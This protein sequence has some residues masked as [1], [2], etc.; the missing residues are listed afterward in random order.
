MTRTI[1][2][3]NARIKSGKV[4]VVTAE[5]LIDRVEEGGIRKA[6]REVDV[7]TTGTMG[8]MCSSGAY[9]NLGQ[10]KP[11][12]KLGGGKATL[13]DVPV[14]TG[15]AAGDFIIGAGALPETDP[16]NMIYPGRFPY[17]GGHVIED[18]AA[19]KDLPFIA[20]AYGTDC[21]P[22]KELAVQVNIRD[23]NQAI[24][25]NPRNLYQNY[26]VAVNLSDRLIYTYMGILKP[27]LGNANYCS[28]GQLSPLLKDPFFRTLGIGTRVFLGGGVGYIAWW[29]TQHNTAVETDERGVPAAPAGTAALIG[30]LK[31][32]SPKWLKGASFTGYGATLAVGVGVPIPILNE[33]VCRYAALKDRDLTTRVVDYSRDYPQGRSAVLARVSYEELKSGTIRVQKREVP[34][35]SLSSYPRAREI[36]EILKGWIA[37][38]DFFLTERVAEFPGPGSGYTYRPLKERPIGGE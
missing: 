20:H 25:F 38:G 19:G 26:N 32:M 28:A 18:L 24:L 17:G 15:L 34:T 4:V 14:Y 30:D 31:Q 13:N 3:I 12:M 22:R 21:Y 27:D 7:V 1:A 8:P 9:F 10:G 35:A 5:E 33:D 11:K 36:A 6:A 16:R 37:K 29:G 2:E 23:F